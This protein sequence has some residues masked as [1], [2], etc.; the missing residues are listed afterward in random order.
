MPSF[1]RVKWAKFRVTAV[2]VVA[3]LILGTLLF[4][5]FGG[6]L[7]SPK[8]VIYLYIPD[9]SGINGESPVRVDGID[10]GRVSMVELSGSRDATRAVKVTLLFYRD[11]LRGVPVDSVAQ[12]SSDSLI[13]DKFVDINGG[14]S[15]QTIPAE[16]ELIY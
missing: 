3:V 9:A 4:E 13:G 16:G 10:V 5:L 1:A 11:R 14:S 12:I 2:S 7:L 15:L 6:M 8:T